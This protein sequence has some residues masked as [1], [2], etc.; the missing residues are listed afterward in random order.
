MTFL[1]LGSSA[2][3]INAARELRL[4]NSDAKIIVAS[5][6]DFLYSRCI[7]HHY[8]EDIR[9]KEQLRF[10]GPEVIK[11]HNI[12]FLKNYIAINLDEKN[13]EVEFS[14]GEKIK[15]DKLL[16]ATGS[17]SAVPP[18]ENV[19]EAK[20]VV[21]LRNFE[22]AVYIKEQTDKLKKVAIVGAGLVGMDT[23]EALALKGVEVHLIDFADRL[24]S[25]QLDHKSSNK[26][27]EAAQKYNVKFHFN[28]LAKKV[29]MD[30]INNVKG[31]ELNDGTTIDVNLIVLAA[32]TKAN[33]DFIENT[34]IKTHTCG[35][36]IDEYCQ[37]NVKDIYAAGDVTGK[38]PI[39]PMAVKE[40]VIAAQNM[41]GEKI[42][43]DD[44]FASKAT[45]NFFKVPTL[46]LGIHTPTKEEEKDYDI[47]TKV[48]YDGTYHK[49]VTKDGYIVGAIIQG[50]LDFSGILTQIIKRHLKVDSF[51]KDIFDVNYSDFFK[52]DNNV[53]FEF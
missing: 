42:V 16:I 8:I 51:D 1:I 7:L 28:V 22:D 10:A 32:G 9:N 2:A 35:I 15:Y 18:I 19:K 50:T 20:Q 27:I 12:D 36:E 46:S 17:S 34:S 47:L 24:L 43:M 11:E 23:L 44:M 29:L 33:M 40:G 13:K 38:N 21:G 4:K 25:L 52:L 31:L 53:E 14:N 6:D 30:E 48:D 5:K 49:L 45:M 3:G 39:W 41:S 26:Y 37:T